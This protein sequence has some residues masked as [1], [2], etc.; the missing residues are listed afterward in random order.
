MVGSQEGVVRLTQV[1]CRKGRDVRQARCGPFVS[2]P[3]AAD[4]LEPKGTWPGAEVQRSS[5]ADVVPPTQRHDL[6]HSVMSAERGK[7]VAF[8]LG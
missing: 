8:P 2:D 1:K 5:A 6:T 4:R 7:P 3:E